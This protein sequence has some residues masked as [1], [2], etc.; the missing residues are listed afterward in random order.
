LRFF[1]RSAREQSPAESWGDG[2]V[3]LHEDDGGDGEIS[4]DE[5]ERRTGGIETLRDHDAADHRRLYFWWKV[6]GEKMRASGVIP[7]PE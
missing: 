4:V 3:E 2:I 1:R 7:T 6:V 5:A